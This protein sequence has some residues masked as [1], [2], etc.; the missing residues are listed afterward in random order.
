MSRIKYI[1]FESGQHF[2]IKDTFKK[3]FTIDVT[4]C[5]FYKKHDRNYYPFTNR[6]SYLYNILIIT[7]YIVISLKIK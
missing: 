1:H 4:L 2:M 3:V 5:M 7:Y 6:V